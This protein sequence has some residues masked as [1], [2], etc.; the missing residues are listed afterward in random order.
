MNFGMI[1]LNENIKTMQNYVIRIL[2]A[3]FFILKLR[4]FIKILQKML[5]T[6]MIYQIMKLIDHYQKQ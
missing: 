6:A 4:I 3:L 2:T 5:K 1:I